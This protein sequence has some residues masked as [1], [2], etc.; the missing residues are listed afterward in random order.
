MPALGRISEKFFT[1]LITRLG[2]KPPFSNGFEMS[3]VVTP[4]SIVDQDISLSTVQSPGPLLDLPF[5]NGDFT[6]PAVGTVLADTGPQSAGDYFVRILVGSDGAQ[7]NPLFVEIARRN[8]ANN[9]DLWKAYV[10]I[11]SGSM[12]TLPFDMVA[13]IR[14]NVNE[15]LVVRVGPTA[16]PAFT[17]GR[18]NLWL[19]TL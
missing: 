2:I 8:A 5:T 16:W 4:V 15:R 11:G 9:G 12:I 1:N 6:A 7:N 18:A 3:N 14:L 19:T 13:R 10:P 17:A